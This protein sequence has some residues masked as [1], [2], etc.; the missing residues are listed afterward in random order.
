MSTEQ[1]NE[2]LNELFADKK[3][4]NFINHLV[5]AYVPN[6]KVETVFV[7]P[8][9]GFQCVLSKNKL[10]TINDLIA[11]DKENESTIL[12]YSS[13]VSSGVDAPDV[14]LGKDLAI[15]GSKTDTY[16]SL[17]VYNAFYD[18]V[19]AEF[20]TGNKHIAWLLGKVDK[21]AFMERA[22]NI[23][24]PKVQK[25]V[26]KANKKKEKDENGNRAMYAL[27]DL[28]ALQALKDKLGN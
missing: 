18:W 16:M 25:L 1:I 3:A 9:K 19:V 11:K 14:V 6:N 12:G 17:D 20:L 21:N 10:V 23:D 5:R 27:G 13:M 15:Q 24:N 26:N 8:N 4:R 7:K 28:S 2:K 22:K